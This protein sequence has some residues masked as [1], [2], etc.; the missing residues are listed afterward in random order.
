MHCW[1]HSSAEFLPLSVQPFGAGRYLNRVKAGRGPAQPK[2]G[3]K[4]KTK[5]VMAL[6]AVAAAGIANVARAD[7]EEV[8]E[9]SL[10]ANGVRTLRI[11]AGAGGLS[12]VGAAGT[13]A[14]QVTARIEVPGGSDDRARKRIESDMVLSLEKDGDEAELRAWFDG[15]TWG[16]SDSPHIHLEVSMPEGLDLAVDDGS[17]PIEVRNVRGDIAIDDGSGSLEMVDVGGSVR[18]DDG[19]GSITV[20]NA[21]GDVYIN[22]GSGAIDVRGVAGSVTV[23]DG[24]GNIDVSDVT[25]DL[26]IV[27]DG[28]GGLDF[29]NIGGRI[30]KES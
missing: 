3:L 24:S 19:S 26:I 22:D 15:S 8:R 20:R 2:K 4:M 21:G 1:S 13:D 9:L 18:I 5:P 14:I 23:D 6:L 28:S 10:G 25:E 29:S 27:D 17:G 7:Y 12:I 16:W 30:E 11:D